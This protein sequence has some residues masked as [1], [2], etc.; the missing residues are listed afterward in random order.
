MAGERDV[1][2]NDDAATVVNAG[3]AVMVE[4]MTEGKGWRGESGD[5]WHGCGAA[6]Y[7]RGG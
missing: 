4:R 6:L 3:R 2:M 7:N 5:G 1:P